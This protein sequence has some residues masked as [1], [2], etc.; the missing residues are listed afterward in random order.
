MHPYWAVVVVA[1]AAVGQLEP[2]PVILM[3]LVFLMAMFSGRS[4][5]LS[6]SELAL[7]VSAI[8]QE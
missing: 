1:V 8:L 4:H 7:L 5:R 6:F 3:V 2:A